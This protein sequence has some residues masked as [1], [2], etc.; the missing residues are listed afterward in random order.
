MSQVRVNVQFNS[1]AG[2]TDV[3]V[4]EVENSTQTLNR[5]GDANYTLNAGDYSITLNGTSPAGGSTTVSIYIDGNL[6]IVTN[7]D[8]PSENPFNIPP[9][10]FSEHREI[11][12][13]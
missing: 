13:P 11:T 6:A 4:V 2:H 12:I 9:G 1:G 10:V 5:S 3:N 7:S 8:E